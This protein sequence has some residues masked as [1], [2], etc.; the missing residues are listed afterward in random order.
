MSESSNPATG[1]NVHVRWDKPL[2]PANGGEAILLVQIAAAPPPE[3]TPRRQAPLDVAFVLD[4]S[5]SMA[6]DKLQLVKEAVNLAVSHLGDDDRAALVVYDHA[7]DILAPLQAATPRA[8][9]TLRLA[10]HGVDAG[11]STDLGGGWLT[12]CHELGRVMDEQS[13]SRV[14]RTLLLTDGL[15]NLGITDPGELF[16]HAHELRQ[17]GIGTTTLGVGL[18]FDETLLEGMAEAGGG[19]FQFIAEASLLHAFFERELQELLTIA[20]TGLSVTLTLPHGVRAHLVTALPRERQGKRITVSPGDLPARDELDLVFRLQVAPGT[21]GASHEIALQLTWSDP[22]ADVSRTLTPEVAPLQY[23][24][25]A[26]IT[27][28]AS[29]SLVAE[30]TALQ[31]ATAERKEAL[32]LDRAGRYTE[33]RARMR[34][35]AAVLQ[36][37]PPSALVMED[38]AVTER[39][40][41]TAEAAP[42]TEYDRKAGAYHNARRGRG[43]RDDGA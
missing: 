8:K 14:R 40:A 4:R 36:A 39:F 24:T 31:S 12:G 9:T 28:T 38:L 5:G 41:M 29:D 17:R 33:S 27:A 2:V 43:K 10:L 25:D 1:L 35:A 23:A 6:G 37:A 18:D 22:S 16:T 34:E 32:R 13:G 20:A 26:D 21:I 3:T 15:A 42:Y 30:R 19:N 11:G 7:V